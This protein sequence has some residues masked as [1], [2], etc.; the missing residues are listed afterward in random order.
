M[1]MM[2]EQKRAAHPAIEQ[3][4]FALDPDV[5]KFDRG[6]PRIHS[7]LTALVVLA[8][9]T[10][11]AG[12]PISQDGETHRWKVVVS[13]TAGKVDEHLFPSTFGLHGIETYEWSDNPTYLKVDGSS[14]DPSQ[15]KES[16]AH[17]FRTWA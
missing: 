3:A 4:R 17:I 5:V 7:I 1:C 6:R 15:P 10:G 14:I 13:G 16:T 8:I 12:V 2:T 9:P 11:V